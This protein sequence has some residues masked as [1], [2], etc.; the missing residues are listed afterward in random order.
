M[1][2]RSFKKYLEKRLGKEEIAEIKKE[3]ELEI[4]ILRL[5]KDVQKNI[6]VQKDSG[7]FVDCCKKVG[8]QDG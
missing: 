6:T 5:A 4:R 7:L 3:V 2:T 8:K 1:R